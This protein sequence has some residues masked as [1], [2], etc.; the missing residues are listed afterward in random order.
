[1]GLG[2]VCG[3][4][5]C[6]QLQPTTQPHA[7]GCVRLRLW[8]RRFVNFFRP[9]SVRL[10]PKKAKNRTGPDF[11]TLL[12][13]AA[14]D[15]IK[16][17]SEARKEAA[18][19]HDLARR[20]MKDRN[21]GKFTPFAK[22]DKVWLEAQNLK[23]LYEN[24]KFAP[25]WEGPFSISEVLSSITYRLSIPL[26]WKIHNTFH[27]SLLS[28][29]RE[30]DVHSPNYMRPP[31]DLIRTEEKYEVEAIITHRGSAR[32]RSYLVHWKGYSSAED[33]WEPE[34]NLEH[35]AD[36]LRAYKKAHPKAFSPRTRTISVNRIHL[37]MS[38]TCTVPYAHRLREPACPGT[39]STHLLILD[40]S[41]LA[42]PLLMAMETDSPLFLTYQAALQ[43][44][45]IENLG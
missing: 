42:S 44:F 2:P 33:S 4:T 36:L 34:A 43:A 6:N 16:E 19:T 5:G 28:P 39:L 8:L 11:K 30:N 40:D 45:W 41:R 9:V 3:E 12:I 35:A 22:G 37:D 24:R 32:N 27:A 23:C 15:H 10:C 17:P 13:P 14:K 21:S 29:Y 18:A 38:P 1:M 26:K 25:K 7:T 31:P 20:A